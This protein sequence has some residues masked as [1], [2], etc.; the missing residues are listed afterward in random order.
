MHGNRTSRL[1]EHLRQE[2]A[3]IIHRE[4]KDPRLGFVTITRVELSKDLTHA[5]VF[6][7]CL[8]DEAER[9]RSQDALDHSAGFIHSL[10]KKRFRLKRIPEILFRYDASIAGSVAMS[11]VLDRLKAQE[12]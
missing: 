7:S 11:D 10:I 4:L 9:E 6:F 8:G 3:L 5:K 12:T 1:E 2:I